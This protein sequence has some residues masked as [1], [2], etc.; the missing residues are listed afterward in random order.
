MVATILQPESVTFASN[1][2]YSNDSPNYLYGKNN[3]PQQDTF[4]AGVIQKQGSQ[5]PAEIIDDEVTVLSIDLPQNQ[6]TDL[7]VVWQPQYSSLTDADKATPK[8][9]PL[10]NWSL[11]SH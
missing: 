1:P 4:G 5:I 6:D 10:D 8:N 11:T 7:Q 2:A 3:V 9:V